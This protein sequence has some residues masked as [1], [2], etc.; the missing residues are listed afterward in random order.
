M[1]IKNKELKFSKEFIKALDKIFVN[2]ENES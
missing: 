2:R 1:E